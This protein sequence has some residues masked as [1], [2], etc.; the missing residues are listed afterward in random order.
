MGGHQ[1]WRKRVAE[2]GIAKGSGGA[3]MRHR[4]RFGRKGHAAR[5]EMRK[6]NIAGGPNKK[7]KHKGI[8]GNKEKVIAPPQALKYN[9][10]LVKMLALSVGVP[11]AL[12][13][14]RIYQKLY[15]R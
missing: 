6:G 3:I 10:S 14:W 2:G 1:A 11:V 8:K 13:V 9:H 15:N 5:L 7:K 4:P 12:S